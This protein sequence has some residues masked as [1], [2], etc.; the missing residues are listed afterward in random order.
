MASILKRSGKNGKIVWQA[1]IRKKGYPAHIKTFDRKTDAKRW[2]QKIEH[3][4]D[5]GLWK[6]IKEASK[7]TL[8][9][10]IDRYLKNITPTKR[11]STQRSEELSANY[12]KK[13]M[14]KLSLL[15]VTPEKVAEYRDT[16]LKSVS[17]NSVRIELALLS[18]LFNIALKEW[19]FDGLVN[20]V[21]RIKKPEVPEGRCP[22]LNENQIKLLLDKCKQSKSKFLHDFVLLILH[23]GCRSTEI[24]ALRWTHVNLED[25]FITLIATETKG[26]KSRVVPLSGAAKKILENLADKAKKKHGADDNGYPQ[27]VVFPAQGNINKPRDLHK[28]FGEARKLAG[29][30]NLPGIGALR[31]HDIRHVCATFM[32]M[33]GA[34]L[35]TVREILGHRDLST[36]QKYLHVV[37]AHKKK[38][39]D[40]IGHLGI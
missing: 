24:R 3:E 25:G 12:L 32:L 26:K 34:D 15:Q 29:L 28:A 23:T 16:R 6:N 38:A 7:I 1:Q 8:A 37:N 33:N 11:L 14:G 22:I 2:A 21:S 9:Q 10:A 36:T 27:G 40:K 20:P 18:N 35:E 39:I 30:D 31:I 17:S 13:A 4:I 19:S 5:A